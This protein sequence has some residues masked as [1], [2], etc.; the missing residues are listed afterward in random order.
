M[1]EHE[2]QLEACLKRRKGLHPSIYHVACNYAE[3]G[4]AEEVALAKIKS[5]ASSL[6]YTRSSDDREIQSAVRAAYIKILGNAGEHPATP[7]LD[8]YSPSCAR[9]IAT[10]RDISIEQLAD[11]SPEEPPQSAPQALVSLFA[12]DELVCLARNFQQ[13]KTKPME[14]WLSGCCGNINI[15]QFVVPNPMSSRTGMTQAGDKQSPRARNNTGPRRRIVCDFDHPR[16]EHQPSIIAHLWDYCGDAPE[17]VLTSGGKSLHAWWRC[18]GLS[19]ESITEFETEATRVGADPNLLT[20][21]RK[22][23]LVRLPCGRRDNGN[24]QQVF[25]W[26]PSPMNSTQPIK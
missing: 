19:Q 26:N 6:H 24:S 17:L 2:N 18:D 9:Q 14:S 7:R 10:T 11:Q 12:G 15:Y 25:F 16:P 8:R 1:L 5:D 22:N 21:R 20:E 3:S 13:S 4:V 23:Q